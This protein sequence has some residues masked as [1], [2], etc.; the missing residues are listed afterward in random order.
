MLSRSSLSIRNLIPHRRPSV[1]DEDMS[2]AESRNEDGARRSSSS[3]VRK[4]Q[5]GG[6]TSIHVAAAK[7]RS[8]RKPRASAPAPFIATSPLT[9]DDVLRPLPPLPSE[10]PRSSASGPD[11]CERHVECDCPILRSRRRL[12]SSTTLPRQVVSADCTPILDASSCGAD[13]SLPSR[14]PKSRFYLSGR[15]PPKSKEDLGPHR[16]LSSE[17]EHKEERAGDK[18][19]H[20]SLDPDLLKDVQQFMQET[21]DA[22]KA[23]GATISEVGPVQKSVFPDTKPPRLSIDTASDVEEESMPPTPPPKELP[24]PNG[25]PASRSKSLPARMSSVFDTSPVSSPRIGPH[26]SSIPKRR[27]S[28]KKSS[29][30]TRPMKSQRKTAALKHSAKGVP[31]WTLTENVSEL[32]TGRLFH[33]HKIEADEMLTPAEIEAYKQLREKKLREEKAAEEALEADAADTSDV[34]DAA[35]TPVEPFHL[36][37][38][39]ARIGSAGVIQ[40]STEEETEKPV[41]VLPEDPVQRTVSF[42][43]QHQHKSSISSLPP[44]RESST[45]P[46]PQSV[47]KSNTFP[48][49]PPTKSPSRHLRSAS[50]GKVNELPSIPE[51]AASTEEYVYLNASPYS[52]TT[53]RLRH[54]PIRLNKADLVPEVKL[55]DEG[56]DWTAFQMAILGGAG[57]WFT[58]SDDTIRRREAEEADD[59][60]EWWESWQFRST[61]ELITSRYEAPSPTSTLSGD[62]IPDVVSY[63]DIKR[64]NPYRPHHAWQKN[65][66]ARILSTSSSSS[67]SSS[68]SSG[69]DGLQLSLDLGLTAKGAPS[70][71]ANAPIDASWRLDSIEQKQVVAAVGRDS[72]GSL[73]PSPMLD[74]RVIR[75]E[76]GDDFDVVPMGYNLGHDLGDFLKWEAEHAYAGDFSSP[77]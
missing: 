68:L 54:G 9:H 44:D 33:L 48:M 11:R 77:I 76:N 56:L 6:N 75:S 13:D 21:E 17:T 51:A 22:F 72:L 32:L 28:S 19:T 4:D 36:D 71:F 62:E 45:T 24:A 42:E 43:K 15:S 74:L 35:D 34:A 41:I 69:A 58:D 31:R 52:M 67:S 49:S 7:S 66:T 10:Y 40:E 2:G 20:G 57:D 61:G 39:P 46:T 37:D 25:T 23:I 12:P 14:L 3:S 18:E 16:S 29:K 38:L 63:N 53:P 60:A 8:I 59:I 47:K 64:D 55:A 30:R 65:P 73:P 5:D 50:R 70:F 26:T 1:S 27:K